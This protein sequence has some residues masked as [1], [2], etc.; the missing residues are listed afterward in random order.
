MLFS[1][2]VRIRFIVSGWLCTRIFTIGPTAV[3]S[4]EGG[5]GSRM[6]RGLMLRM[7]HFVVSDVFKNICEDI[8]S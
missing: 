1:C 3:S 5:G 2:W 4:G 8:R 7:K 6:L